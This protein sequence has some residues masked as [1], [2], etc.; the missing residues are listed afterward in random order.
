MILIQQFE[1]LAVSISLMPHSF[2]F[3]A[4]ISGFTRFV[5]ETE[6]SH[7][8]HIVSELLEAL[9]EKNQMN[10]DVAEI[11]GDAVL[12][13]KYGEVP[14]FNDILKQ[15]EAMFLEFHSHLLNYKHKRICHC[16]AC[17]TAQD[18]TVKFISHSGEFSFLKVKDFNKPHGADVVL[19]HKLLKNN[20]PGREYLL[21]TDCPPSEA[22]DGIVTSNSW[23]KLISGVDEYE[24]IG[25]VHYGYVPFEE[26]HSKVSVKPTVFPELTKNPIV[27][28]GEIE[29]EA[30]VLFEL[31]SN[32]DF[33]DQWNDAPQSLEYEKGRVNRV[34][35]RHVCV[36]DDHTIEFETVANDFGSDKLVY[37]E[38]LRDYQFISEATNYFILEPQ[39]V[40]TVL[41]IESHIKPKNILITLFSIFYKAVFRKNL[42]NVLSNIEA[43]ANRFKIRGNQ[44][45]AKMAS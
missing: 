2:L 29:L 5:H 8:R 44:A 45:S 42:V 25:E 30:K 17:R 10:L 34:G 39:G 12:F 4:D 41:R 26:L 33:R 15:S 7:S 40:K 9:I 18:L 19:V 43:A 23:V 13:Y 3:I 31:V 28:E 1:L 35:T 6:I 16:G 37:G 24:D 36:F 21:T 38:R 14:D 27:V 20:V 11:E 22:L 32:F